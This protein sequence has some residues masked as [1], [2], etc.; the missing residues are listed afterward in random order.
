M[1]LAYDLDAPFLLFINSVTA[2][3]FLVNAVFNLSQ[4]PVIDIASCSDIFKMG[5]TIPIMCNAAVG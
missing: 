5:I 4:Q 2:I 3:I 1:R